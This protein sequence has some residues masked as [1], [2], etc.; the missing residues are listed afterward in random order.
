MLP[1]PEDILKYH[2]TSNIN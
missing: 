1:Y 2:A